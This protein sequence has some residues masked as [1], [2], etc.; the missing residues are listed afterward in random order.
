MQRTKK[1]EVLEE[2][3]TKQGHGDHVDSRLIASIRNSQCLYLFRLRDEESFL[4]LIWQEIDSTRLLTPRG[5]P[6]TLKEIGNRLRARH[7][8]PQLASPL[9][10]PSTEHCPSW[11]ERC[12]QIDAAFDYDRFG[13]ISVVHPT[14]GERGQSPDGSFACCSGR[15]RSPWSLQSV[16]AKAWLAAT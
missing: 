16:F 8:F 5:Q 3:A 9:D 2:L 6:R 7:D 11:F 10:L 12:I 13:W 1:N 14:D 4:S 15:P